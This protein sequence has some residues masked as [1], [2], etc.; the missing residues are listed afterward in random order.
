MKNNRVYR[1]NSIN[2]AKFPDINKQN[3]PAVLERVRTPKRWYS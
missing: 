2:D 3:I 1:N